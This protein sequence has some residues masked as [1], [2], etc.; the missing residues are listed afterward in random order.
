MVVDLLAGRIA[1]EVL[2]G[3]GGADHKTQL[4]ELAAHRLDVL[5]TYVVSDEGPDH[6]KRFRAEVHLGDRVAGVGEGRSKKLAEQ[7]AAGVAVAALAADHDAGP[8][9][10]SAA[11]AS[12]VNSESEQA[13][14]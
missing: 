2:D 14:A 10:P 6:D 8:V 4:Q 5:P 11:A 3:P 13:H 9:D 7:A 1:A 12:I